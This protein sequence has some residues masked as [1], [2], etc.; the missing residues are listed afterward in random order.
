[1]VLPPLFL[2]ILTPVL[3]QVDCELAVRVRRYILEHYMGTRIVIGTYC[4][5]DRVWIIQVV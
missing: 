1:M 3:V 4:N 2:R 5:L